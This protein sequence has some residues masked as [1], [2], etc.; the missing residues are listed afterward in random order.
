[1]RFR[2]LHVLLVTKF[3]LCSCCS[4]MVNQEEQRFNK[5]QFFSGQ[6]HQISA[7]S[8]FKNPISKGQS[9]QSLHNATI[10]CTL[11]KHVDFHTYKKM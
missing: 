8:F 10:Y 11:L 4:V 2:I 7:G 5:R 9:C 3:I 6:H 1:M